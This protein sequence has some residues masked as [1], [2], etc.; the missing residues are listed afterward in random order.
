MTSSFEGQPSKTRPFPIETRVI[1][2]PGIDKW[3]VIFDATPRCCSKRKVLGSI[4]VTIYPPWHLE[5]HLRIPISNKKCSMYGI[6]GCPWYL[7]T[8]L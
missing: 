6:L 1:W 7:V 4:F 2:V 8:R 5:N 3:S